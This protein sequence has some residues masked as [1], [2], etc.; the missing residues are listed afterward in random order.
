MTK[1]LAS[2]TNVQEA[3]LALDA[4]V[5]IIDLKDPAKGALG[6]LGRDVCSR[7]VDAVG[8]FGVISATVG[9]FPKMDPQAVR[10]AAE[11]TAAL[12][13]HYVKIGFWPT[14][15]TL[16]CATAL[17]P[18]ARHSRLVAVLFADQSQDPR[19]IDALVAAGFSGVMLD[20]ADKSAAPLRLLKTE[21]ELAL[22]VRR[23]R[24]LGML[25]G[26]AGKLRL[27]DVA[28]LLSLQPDYLGFRGALC[29]QGARTGQLDP[30][31]LA[32]VR[33]AVHASEHRL[34]ARPSQ[35]VSRP[36]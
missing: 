9:D 15:H 35:Y 25:C 7:I 34:H 29:A 21:I 17:A 27:P 6:A 20:T 1:M 10:L 3:M 23:V 32:A 16:A 22:F 33:N 19:L 26:L 12:G 28:P 5:D 11:A 4:E 8:S 2:V 14:D 36:Q 18:L 13:V 31:A 30:A 24:A